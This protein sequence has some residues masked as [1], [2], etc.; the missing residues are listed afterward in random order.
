MTD[1][2]QAQPAIDMAA[3]MERYSAWEAA[4]AKLVPENRQQLFAHLAS[5]NITRVVVIFDGEGD[6]GQ[7]EDIQAYNGDEQMPL[8]GGEIA[9]LDLPYGEAQPITR[10]HGIRKGCIETFG[11]LNL[12]D[13][14][15]RLTFT[16]AA[17]AIRI[18]RASS[19]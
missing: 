3:T 14:L 17:A 7:I 18:A 11:T 8:P 4:T 5:A 15:E 19:T 9:T 12:D 13:Q 2:I 10:Q 16:A 1:A 6:S